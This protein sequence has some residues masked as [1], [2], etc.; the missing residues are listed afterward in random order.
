[1]SHKY[2]L[3]KAQFKKLFGTAAMMMENRYHDIYKR[4]GWTQA[5][6]GN[7]FCIDPGAHSDGADSH[8][9]MT[10]KN[11]TGQFF[12][13]ACGLKGNFQSYWSGYLKGKA[14]GEH[15]SDFIIDF[16]NLQNSSI[17]AFSTSEDDPDFEKNKTLLEGVYN[18]FVAERLSRGERELELSNDLIMIAQEETSIP[19]EELNKRVDAL[20]NDKERLDYLYETRRITV[21]QI[22]H[23]KIG[24]TERRQYVFPMFNE[25]GNLSNMKVYDPFTKNVAYKWHYLYKGN[26]VYPGPLDNFT[27][28]T[29]IFCAGEP[30]MY[31]AEAMGL[32]GVVTM[33]AERHTD[34]DKIFGENRARQIFSSKEIIIV[35]D[36]DETGR[37]GAVALAHSLYKYASQ[38]K[39]IDL[40]RSEINPHGLDP[41]IMKEVEAN[42]KT[43]NKRAE[44]DL[45]DYFKK[46]GMN[47]SATLKL[48]Q[49]FNNTI[50]YTENVDRVK[51]EIY[52]VTLQEARM[53]KYSSHDES[54]ELHVTA[55]VAEFND[56]AYHFPSCFSVSCPMTGVPDSDLYSS[57]KRCILPCL[58]DFKSS[59]EIDFHIIRGVVPKEY[60]G[61]PTYIS[62]NPH[63]ILTL[64]ETTDEKMTKALKKLCHINTGCPSTRVVIK[65]PEKL[66]H[67]RLA[68]DAGSYGDS[69]TDKTTD[70]SAIEMDA[71]ING[72]IDI[73]PNRSYKFRGVQT[74]AADDGRA[75]LFVYGVEPI[76]TS[77][78]N[79]TMDGD[80]DEMLRMFRPR[81]DETL[82]Q[83]FKRRYD[84]ISQYAGITGRNNLFMLLD[85]TFFSQTEINNKILFPSV[86]R[87]WVESLIAGDTRCGKT[88]A[89]QFM[90]N[91]YKDGDMVAGSTAVSRTGLIGGTK[92]YK[93]KPTVHWG[94]FPMNDGGT[95]IIDELSSISPEVLTD[96][97]ACRSSGIASIDNLSGSKRAYARA[98]KIFLSNARTWTSEKSVPFNTG[99]KF[100]KHLTMKDEILSRF[101]FAIIVKAADVDVNTF[102]NSYTQT[103]E[104][105][106]SYQSRMCLMWARSRKPEDQV[107]EE[108]FEEHVN[109][110]QKKLLKKFHT[111]TQLINQEVRLKITRG[112]AAVAGLTYS[113]V[114]GDYNKLYITK[115]H[116]T[117]IYELM[118]EIYCHVNMKLDVYS[119]Q[120]RSMEQI[121]DMR[122]ME[123]IL[124]YIDHNPLFTEDEFG[125]KTLMQIFSDYLIRV[126]RGDLQMIDSK[127]DNV[128]M[129]GLKPHISISKLIN[130]L[131]SRNCL[132]RSG[133]L[134]RK[135]EAFNN[136]LNKIIEE[137][138]VYGFSNILENTDPEPVGENLKRLAEYYN[139]HK[140]NQLKLLQG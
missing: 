82:K 113:T 33:T 125:E 16:L 83:H 80:V 1:M 8:A 3:G 76:A 74:Q 101:D 123:N 131:V 90:I 115:E 23:R 133:A 135:T 5:S 134:F 94:K 4:L 52:K 77:F 31:C 6:S 67:V 121:G 122:F 139:S 124:R 15:Y 40:D 55:S 69:T 73:Y 106:T 129:T 104:Q 116:A 9:S 51:K 25:M 102:S 136:W 91:Y 128:K 92:I 62:V 64:I 12:C 87:G 35:Y 93:G 119:E 57:C 70:N 43:K 99:I 61:D 81:H 132:V 100:L 138:S 117:F 84:I 2:K 11:Q 49:L 130:T 109:T 14:G 127:N 30:D 60:R 21:E 26:E 48:L 27:C 18:K 58:K 96:L 75:V 97:T 44:K 38:I 32:K 65:V 103:S 17:L 53:P 46:N 7:F 71:Y 114:D 63:E 88:V 42:G 28:K 22:K 79:F 10:V 20:L 112:S 19:I 66:S 41:T 37:K 95:V 78:E 34:V 120:Q 39:I 72:D 29:I 111:S 118:L 107:F 56:S 137:D 108:G 140:P 110:L 105:F 59:S 54:K 24:L 126:E 45:T 68:R 50:A 36:A 47:E 98:R 89:S 85:L 86:K 13:H